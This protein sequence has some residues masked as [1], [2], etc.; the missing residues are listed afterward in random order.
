MAT[1]RQTRSCQRHRSAPKAST[2]RG[3]KQICLPM[4][5]EQYDAIWADAQQVRTFVE[6]VWAES[7]ELFPGAIANGYRLTGRLPE[8]K[9]LPGIRLRQVRI[10]EQVYSLRPSFVLSYMSGT[11]EALEHPLL[12]LSLGVPCWVVTTVFGGNDMFWH[13]HLERLGRNRLVW[14]NSADSKPIAGP[15]G[16]R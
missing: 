4:S 8:S 16:G 1:I 13:R 3:S 11:V 5:R 15:L 2:A 10:Q 12:L 14:D 6:K 9:K 7:P